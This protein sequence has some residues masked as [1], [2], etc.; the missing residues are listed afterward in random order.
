MNLLRLALLTLLA[1][2]EAGRDFYKILGVPR[3]A[4]TNQIKKAYRK[5][6]KELHP[7]RAG[8]DNPEAHE[9]FQ[10]LGAAYEVLS[11]PDKRKVY[12]RSGEEGVN[13]MQGGGGGGH[14]PFSSF[15]GDFFG[16]G[17][18]HGGDEESPRG[19][20]VNMELWTSLEELYNGAFVEVLRNKAV[21]KPASGTRKCNCRHEMRT[22]QM[23]QGRFQ[24]F[25]EK[26]CDDC[27]NVKLVRE[28]RTLEV[29]IESGMREG[30]SQT[31]RGEGEPH[32]DGDPGDLIFKL[33]VAKHERFERR[34][35]DLFTNLTITLT[36]ALNGFE[37]DIPHLDGHVV[38]ISRE[39]VTWPGARIK[40]PN[41]GMPKHENSNQFG[42]LYVTFD[43]EFPRGELT[44]DEKAQIK[45]ILKQEDKPVKI[46]NGL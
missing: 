7:D 4:N 16:G 21:V 10:D 46:Y 38:K 12:D 44:A 15:F 24:M 5:L 42:T 25:Q 2:A 14:D 33:R 20:D 37:V 28:Q 34:G 17:G 39:K 40:K 36:Q 11:D 18:G 23:G 31:F 13:K 45:A 35:D 9:A 30:M 3:N 22:V 32:I 29:E 19:E 8:D 6:A 26:V 1:L 43:V 41:E 27:P